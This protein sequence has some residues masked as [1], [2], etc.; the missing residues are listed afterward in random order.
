[1]H[2]IA[3]VTQDFAEYVDLDSWVGRGHKYD[4]QI[5]S[6][7]LTRVTSWGD[8]QHVTMM[9]TW[10]DARVKEVTVT[11]LEGKDYTL[12]LFDWVTGQRYH[13]Q[14]VEVAEGKAVFRVKPKQDNTVIAYLHR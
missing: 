14:D 1:M 8:G 3:G 2:E 7:R 13:T 11:G 5:S 9:L 4:D 12:A 6:S 10:A